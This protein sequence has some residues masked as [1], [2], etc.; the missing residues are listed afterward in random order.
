MPQR[1]V[2]FFSVGADR[3]RQAWGTVGTMP[4][5]KRTLLM[6]GLVVISIPLFLLILLV[7]IFLLAMAAMTVLITLLTNAF[8]GPAGRTGPRPGEGPGADSMR[9]NVRV[10]GEHDRQ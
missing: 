3:S 10:I 5:W 6:M 9:Q 1:T 4:A 8:R 2:Q 7:G